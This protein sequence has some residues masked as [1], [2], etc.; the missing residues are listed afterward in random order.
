M[1][2]TKTPQAGT[3]RKAIK[4][5][6]QD[7]SSELEML[8]E[9]YARCKFCGQKYIVRVWLEKVSDAAQTK[10]VQQP[11]VEVA[12]KKRNWMDVLKGYSSIQLVLVIVT[13]ILISVGMVV[14]GVIRSAKQ[15]TE[16][17]KQTYFRNDKDEVLVSEESGE[18]EEEDWEGF[19][20]ETMRQVVSRIFEKDVEEVTKEELASIRYFKMDSDWPDET[21]TITYSMADYRDYQPDYHEKLPDY[22][23]EIT[24]A[25]SKEFR[26]TLTSF[27]VAYMGDEPKYL[28]GDVT[29]FSNV[30]ALNL[31]EY[32]YVNFKKL[33]NVTLLDSERYS[34]PE[35]IE[36]GVPIEQIEVLKVDDEDMTGIEKFTGLKALY[37]LYVD[38][39]YIDDIAL[40]TQLE[41][42]YC[43]D[44]FTGTSYN[45]LKT[46]TGLKTFYIRGTSPTIKD[47]SVISSFTNLENLSIDDTEILS[48]SFV[49]DLKKLKT[50]RL[51]END[52][53]ENFSGLGKVQS[54]ECL[55]TDL[56]GIYSDNAFYKE[57]VK[58]KNLK[59]LALNG[60]DNVDFLNEL[61]QL[62]RLDIDSSDKDM[63][64]AIGKMK[65]LK[66]LTLDR[67]FTSWWNLEEMDYLKELKELRVLNIYSMEFEDAVN[68]VFQ[69]ESLEEL[70]LTYCTFREGPD[71]VLFSDK[72]RVLDLR[73]TKIYGYS[74]NEGSLGYEEGSVA[75]GV[76]NAYTKA[77]AL[78]EVYLDRYEIK[79]LLEISNM[80]SLKRLSLQNCELTDSQ[81]NV[82][83]N[84]TSL[85]YLNLSYNDITDIDFAEN[86]VN[87]QRLDIVDCYVTDLSP[88]LK[89]PALRYVDAKDNPIYLNP[90]VDVKVV[91]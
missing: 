45:P 79:N 58:L 4:F 37:L 73:G 11:I 68:G 89:C 54:L 27:T 90:L 63:L 2:K 48:I 10:S 75:Q 12:E 56:F 15:S 16:P 52:D 44:S 77:P 17:H 9:N 72:L 43:I 6:C 64:S 34:I 57:V 80:P 42:L 60:A 38:A 49:K 65:N 18:S 36:A 84:A 1:K 22:T 5:E 40:C 7:C 33:P 21:Y 76:L 70:H 31:D 74:R 24:F 83:K 3:S 78:E 85:E 53:L 88:L 86:L 28:Y 14:F 30:S 66:E 26:D 81:K 67:C 59:T 47:L 87:L 13:I 35:L 46:L 51:A 19:R 32:K 23:G 91:Y 71:E 69:V 29:N 25:Y 62:E 8:E 41:T 55:I 61:P 82:L 50:L 20:S 39:E